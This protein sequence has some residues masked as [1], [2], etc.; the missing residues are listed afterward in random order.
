MNGPNG[1]VVLLPLLVTTIK[2]I[3][4]IDAVMEPTKIEN[5]MPSRPVK[6]PTIARRSIS[7]E[8]MPSFFVN[9]KNSLLTT[10]KDRYPTTAPANAICQLVHVYPRYDKTMPAGIKYK[11]TAS[12]ISMCSRSV[13]I[14]TS[15]AEKNRN[16]V[17]NICCGKL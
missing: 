6:L 3:P 4:I 8:P 9:I 2:I 1:S 17:K 5:Q 14:V 7:P 16:A 10:N 12:E 11:V 15:S 13:R